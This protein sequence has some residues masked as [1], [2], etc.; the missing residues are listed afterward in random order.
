MSTQRF[1]HVDVFERNLVSHFELAIIMRLLLCGKF[2]LTELLPGFVIARVILIRLVERLHGRVR[3]EVEVAHGLGQEWQLLLGVA[4]CGLTS[5]TAVPVGRLESILR[6]FMRLY[7]LRKHQVIN[8]AL[9]RLDLLFEH[10]LRAIRRQLDRPRLQFL[11][12]TRAQ[13][14]LF[15]GPVLLGHG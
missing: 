3:A 13:P 7:S 2:G 8:R 1:L 15:Y 12:D 5:D 6:R 10:A 14:R 9:D 11:L 4:H